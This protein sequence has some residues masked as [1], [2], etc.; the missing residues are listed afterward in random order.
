MIRTFKMLA[1]TL[2]VF[3]HDRLSSYD[4]RDHGAKHR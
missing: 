4:R 3:F 1:V 2:V